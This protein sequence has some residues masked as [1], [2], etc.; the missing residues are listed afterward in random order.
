MTNFKAILTK[1]NLWMIASNQTLIVETETSFIL[2]PTQMVST[3]SSASLDLIDRPAQAAST[4]SLQLL[5][6]KRKDVEI[7]RML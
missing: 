2:S 5:E 4:T 6:N 1:L 3:F 7:E